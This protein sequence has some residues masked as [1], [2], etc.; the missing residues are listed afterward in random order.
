MDFGETVLIRVEVGYCA[1]KVGRYWVGVA[2]GNRWARKHRRTAERAL[3]DAR[4][5]DA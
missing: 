4:D 5:L 2:W 1:L 3:R